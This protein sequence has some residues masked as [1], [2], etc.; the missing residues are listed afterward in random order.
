M[1]EDQTQALKPILKEVL[2]ELLLQERETL[3]DV[4][5]EVIEDMALAKAIEEGLHDE[6]VSREEIFSLLAE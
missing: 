3:T 1:L 2:H 5:Y 4:I 6:N